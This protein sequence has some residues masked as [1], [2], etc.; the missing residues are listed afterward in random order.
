[1]SWTRNYRLVLIWR[2]NEK[3][4]TKW[5]SYLFASLSLILSIFLLV[6]GVEI[7]SAV[8][9]PNHTSQRKVYFNEFVQNS[10]CCNM[11]II[12]YYLHFY[13]G[14]NTISRILEQDQRSWFLVFN[15]FLKSMK[16]HR[17][18]HTFFPC[19]PLETPI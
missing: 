15:N 10:L 11:G 5:N 18:I 6:V 14:Q 2:A 19:H 9:P 4:I 17:Y 13:G 7:D 3:L 8:S 1:M 12:I 16:I